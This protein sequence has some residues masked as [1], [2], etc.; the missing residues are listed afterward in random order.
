M[1]TKK[2]T[3]LR[4]A[5]GSLSSV[6]FLRFLKESG[7]RVIGTD[8]TD[9][10]VGKF[11]T[12]RF[13]QIAEA[14]NAKK[15]L[16]DYGRIIKKEK[17]SWLISGPE[18]EILLF[19]RNSRALQKLGATVFHPPLS[20]LEIITDKLRLF[21]FMA[22]F[23]VRMPDT[24]II[25]NRSK[26][27][28]GKI[29]LKPRRGRGSSGVFIREVSGLMPLI[30]GLDPEAYLIQKHISGQ[31]YTVDALYDLQGRV[32]NIVPRRRLK[33]DSGICVIGETVKDEKLL[34]SVLKISSLL[35]FR[36]GNCFQFIKDKS[37]DY[38]LT[39]IN[40][41]FGGGFSISLKASDLLRKN[42]IALLSGREKLL[43]HNSFEFKELR[44]YSYYEEV[45]GV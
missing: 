43:M 30:E 28:R 7:F 11:F 15:A 10:A 31:E 42:I 4:S 14:S 45:T 25:K 27:P 29:V 20:T 13:Y 41:R 2:M 33:T 8:I 35:Q 9:L 12:D 39:D 21:D 3:I 37:G 36:G 44:S 16:G 24:H 32:L 1:S 22:D 23:G 40:P 38:Y 5:V 17:V 19:A 18:S 26:F 6:S 34:E